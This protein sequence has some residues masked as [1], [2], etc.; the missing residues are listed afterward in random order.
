M[1]AR[2]LILGVKRLAN[3]CAVP[4]IVGFLYKSGLAVTAHNAGLAT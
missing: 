1:T 4:S 2:R 3:L